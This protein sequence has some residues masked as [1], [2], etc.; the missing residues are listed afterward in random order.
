ME[1]ICCAGLP[2]DAR[3]ARRL[4][5]AGDPSAPA[6]HADATHRGA[7]SRAVSSTAT[8]PRT[9]ARCRT[10]QHALAADD[11]HDKLR[12]YYA[13]LVAWRLALLATQNS[14]AEG[15]AAAAPLAQRCVSELDGV[16]AA[17]ADFAEA[18]ALRAACLEPPAAAGGGLHLPFAGHGARK[19]IERA[20]A[21]APH[22][23][24][25]LLIDAMGDYELPSSQ[26]GNQER[27]LVKLRQAVAAFE[28]ERG[29]P[30]PAARLGRRG[31]L[32]A[33]WRAICWITGIR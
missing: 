31:G 33:I 23:P 3:A 11:A 14:P 29:G 6:V 25:V 2:C 13:G 7:I 10:S 5:A 19:D 32:P 30:G 17:Q 26:G 1:G 12:G 8:T 28:V 21:L 20:L 27:A 15:R 9:V 4:A 24:R 16:L 22:N 18:L